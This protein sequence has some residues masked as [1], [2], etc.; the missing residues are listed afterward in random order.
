MKT[1]TLETS[2]ESFEEAHR[3]LDSTRDSSKEI[4]VPRATFSSLLRD[5]AQM[6]EQLQINQTEIKE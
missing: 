4:K 6:W 2:Q 1:I 5:H 3:I